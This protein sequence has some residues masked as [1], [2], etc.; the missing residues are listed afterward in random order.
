MWQELI[1]L[2]NFIQ[3]GACPVAPRKSI[4]LQPSRPKPPEPVK[5]MPEL[6]PHEKRH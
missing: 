1:R 5:L 2:E 6:R 4:S 3:H